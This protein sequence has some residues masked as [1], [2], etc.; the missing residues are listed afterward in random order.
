MEE[1]ASLS[2]VQN[3]YVYSSESNNKVPLLTVSTIENVLETLRI[4]RL[5]HFRT[6]SVQSFTIP[7]A[8]PSEVFSAVATQLNEL[9][10]KLPRGYSILV[11]G[12]QAKQEQGFRNLSIVM[13]ISIA[14]IFIALAIQFRH[15]IKPILVLAAAP[16]GIVG[17][18][19]ALY[20]MGAAFGFMAFLGIASLIG[21][22]VSH[23]IVLFDFIEDMHEK[24]E[25]LEQALLDAGIVRLRPVLIT[26]GATILALFPLAVHGGPLWQP[27]CY[28]QIG[29]L[30]AAT[31][32]T[33]L[34]V[35]VLYSI[36]VLDLNI[37]K[38]AGPTEGTDAPAGA[39]GELH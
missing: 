35:P 14:L 13:A 34:L 26:V 32:I 16:Y 20:V 36:F 3:L 31:F 19:T 23:V 6:I 33:L 2:D 21:V 37:V 4:R 27:L 10:K 24:G 1:R 25:P 11:S 15:A 7:G 5:E 17:A 8:L 18:L 22:I 12:E 38:W 30:G 9:R 39:K 29:G 28:A